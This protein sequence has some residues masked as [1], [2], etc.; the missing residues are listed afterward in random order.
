LLAPHFTKGTS[1][2]SGT[3]EDR[4]SSVEQFIG[5]HDMRLQFETEKLSKE[6][7]DHTQKAQNSVQDNMGK[8]VDSINAKADNLSAKTVESMKR[9]NLF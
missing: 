4:L 3:V 2:S 1:S 8:K 9:L 6:M 5:I 7:A